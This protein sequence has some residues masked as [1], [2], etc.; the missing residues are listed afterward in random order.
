MKYL[1]LNKAAQ[2]AHKTKK[3]LQEAIENGTLSATKNERGHWQIDPAELSRVYS[4]KT[5]DL[6]Q[7][8]SPIPINTID[9]NVENRIEIE[10]LRA[11]L[12]AERKLS[13]MLEQD[14]D[15]WKSQAKTLLIANQNESPSSKVGWFDRML[16]RA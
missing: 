3:T 9:Q 1:S 13:A 16:G 2:A 10:R 11:E 5:T 8:Q 7:D 4:L 15:E 12:E 6:D 14:R